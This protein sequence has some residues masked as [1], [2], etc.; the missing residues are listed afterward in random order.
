MSKSETDRDRTV[1]ALSQKQGSECV[2]KEGLVLFRARLTEVQADD[3][4]VHFTLERLPT[5]GAEDRSGDQ[6]RVS[7]SWFDLDCPWPPAFVMSPNCGFTIFLDGRL[8]SEV[9]KLAAS[10]AEFDDVVL[11]LNELLEELHDPF[12][13]GGSESP[14]PNEAD[15][16]A[17][18]FGSWTLGSLFR[19]LLGLGKKPTKA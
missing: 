15:S 12:R 18:A 9:T 10:G 6:S 1:K 4:C 3:E 19:R 7:F 13:V 5:W 16:T 14:P 11:R 17:M 8:V 2:Y